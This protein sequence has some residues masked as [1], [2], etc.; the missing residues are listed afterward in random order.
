MSSHEF[1][2][3]RKNNFIT[4]DTRRCEACWDCVEACPKQVLGK[5]DVIWHRH[6]I[7]RNAEACN[8]CKKCVRACESG[9]I[10]YIYVPRSQAARV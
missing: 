4:M 3:R 1:S 6:A 10:E 9:A 5:I 8:G 7:I 2:H